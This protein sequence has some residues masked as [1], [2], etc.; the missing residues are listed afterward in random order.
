M[1]VVIR[2]AVKGDMPELLRLGRAFF[3][4][5]PLSKVCE[6]NET[7]ARFTLTH[8]IDQQAL[9]QAQLLVS[10]HVPNELPSKDKRLGGILALVAFPGYFNA[11]SR[12]VQ[13]LF[14]WAEDGHG[15]EL[16]SKGQLWVAE[17]GG[18]LMMLSEL[19]RGDEKSARAYKR[20]GFVPAERMYLA[21]VGKA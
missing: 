8:L 21:A 13:E 17:T 10:D 20:M 5:S 3:E 18:A 14:W 12:M 19:G 2:N 4:A 15:L 9:G 6:F 16:L 11:H 1:P 7:T